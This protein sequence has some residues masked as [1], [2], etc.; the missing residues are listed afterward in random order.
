LGTVFG[1]TFKWERKVREMKMK[2]INLYLAEITLLCHIR[3]NGKAHNSQRHVKLT[4]TSKEGCE[5]FNGFL[6]ITVAEK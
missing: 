3:I 4:Q 6:H 1:V 2:R 5:I